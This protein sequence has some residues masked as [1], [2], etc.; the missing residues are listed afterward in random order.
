MILLIFSN[1]FGTDFVLSVALLLCVDGNTR[2]LIW[3][4][5]IIPQNQK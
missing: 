1:D 3:L 4:F 5:I 2:L